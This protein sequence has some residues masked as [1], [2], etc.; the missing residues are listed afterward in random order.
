MNYSLLGVFFIGFAGSLIYKYK[1][2][3][4]IN[5]LK[6]K[7][8]VVAKQITVDFFMGLIYENKNIELDEAILKFE[9]ANKDFTNIDSFS[10]G[11]SRT[12]D[13]YRAAYYDLFMEAKRRTN[14]K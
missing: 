10:K 9:N 4:I 1:E 14:K 11:K 13:Q 5:Y 7:T 8:N 12:A 6:Y 2:L 3:I